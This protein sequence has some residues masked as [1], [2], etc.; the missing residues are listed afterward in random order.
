MSELG[1]ASSLFAA[2][3]LFPD[4]GRFLSHLRFILVY[5]CIAYILNTQA[6]RLCSGCT[7]DDGVFFNS[8]SHRAF[9]PNAADLNSHHDWF[10]NGDVCLS[11]RL[12]RL[13]TGQVLE[14]WTVTQ[15]ERS[16]NPTVKNTGRSSGTTPFLNQWA[17]HLDVPSSRI[18][19][20]QC[21]W[22]LSLQSCE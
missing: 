2:H 20:W 17:P 22:P 8:L 1:S 5:A 9:I 13:K 15:S 7:G 11:M 21:F 19:K 14:S 18:V 12:W 4:S 6:S 10:C 16:P 3:T